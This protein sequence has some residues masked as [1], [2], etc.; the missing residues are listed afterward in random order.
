MEESDKETLDPSSCLAKKR[1]LSLS[2]P[3]PVQFHFE[4]DDE[5]QFKKGHL[6]TAFQVYERTTKEQMHEASR[7]LFGNSNSTLAVSEGGG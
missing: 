7:D 2:L 4:T 5:E 3:K 6:I 1:C